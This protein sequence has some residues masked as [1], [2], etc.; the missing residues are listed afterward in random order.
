MHSISAPSE[1]N[2]P[3]TSGFPVWHYDGRTAQRRQPMLVVEG[4]LFYLAGDGAA[5]DKYELSRLIAVG[6]TIGGGTFGLRGVDGWRIGFDNGPPPALAARLPGSR[7][8]GGLIDR[9]G[10]WPAAGAS[11][12]VA[13]V[14]VAAFLQ[15]PSLV[16]EVVPVSVERRLGDVMVGDFGNRLCSTPAGDAALEKLQA[17]LAPGNPDAEIQVANLP[18]VNAITL[19]G[20]RII[21]FNGLVQRAVSADEVA[22]VVGHELGHV[23]HRDVIE[24]LLRQLGLSVLLGGLDG[25]VS[26]YTNA[27]LS[28][29]YS[30]DAERRADGFAIDAL[31]AAHISPEPTAGFFKRL[32]GAEPKDRNTAQVLNYLSSHPMS[33]DRAKRFGDAARSHG[34]YVAALT[35][36]DWDDL[37][38]ICKG[39]PV[40]PLLKFQM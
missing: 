18:V 9:F 30:R 12:V 37:R 7:R 38:S 15:V 36:Q 27:L 19:P 21:L 11:A 20:G 1:G 14:A 10:L 13:L 8:Y 32:S 26:G 5:Q 35:A 31:T 22:G 4:A 3:D 33:T 2:M 25:R 23:D 17:K 24:S 28:S 6:S 34:P 16:A 40:D 39:K 29:A